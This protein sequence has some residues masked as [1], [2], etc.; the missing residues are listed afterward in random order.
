MADLNLGPLEGGPANLTSPPGPDRH[1]CH[2]HCH[3]GTSRA[4]AATESTPSA[5]DESKAFMLPTEPES[6]VTGR[7]PA[8]GLPAA[9]PLKPC[10]L[11]AV[12]P[13]Q[14][15]LVSRPSTVAASSEDILLASGTA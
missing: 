13:D 8:P 6:R 9:E 11:A 12:R 3:R 4:L 1:G 10:A 7:P 5:S 2:W 15:A 14:Q